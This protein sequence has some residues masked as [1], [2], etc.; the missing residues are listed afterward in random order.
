MEHTSL[1]VKAL[2][3]KSLQH[4]LKHFSTMFEYILRKSCIYS[5]LRSHKSERRCV[6]NLL[7]L[8]DFGHMSLF[9]RVEI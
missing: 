4:V 8:D 1:D 2:V 9:G 7:L 5:W 6:S 3:V